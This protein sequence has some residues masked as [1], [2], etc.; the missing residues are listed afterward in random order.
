MTTDPATNV[1]LFPSSDGWGQ[2]PANTDGWANPPTETPCPPDV[3]H[4]RWDQAA[5][6]HKS[7]STDMRKVLGL[8]D[9]A[10][11]V[12][13]P[14]IE[15]GWHSSIRALERRETITRHKNGHW[16]LTPLGRLVLLHHQFYKYRSAVCSGYKPWL[17][18][19]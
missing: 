18:R 11:I 10:T 8:L 1:T 12:M 2:T 15:G 3:P 17:N 13:Q 9:H 19:G 6:T 14:R 7:M 4:H 16:V 5:E